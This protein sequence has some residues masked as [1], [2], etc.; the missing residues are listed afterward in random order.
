MTSAGKWLLTFRA[1]LIIFLFYG[2]VFCSILCLTAGVALEFAAGFA[3]GR[4]HWAVAVRRAL[5]THF[6]LLK[7]FARGLC[8]SKTSAARVLLEPEAAPELFVMIETLCARTQ[9]VAP[10]QLWLEMQLNAWVRLGGFLP[11]RGRVVL[12]VGYDLLAG[13]TR[14]EL[15]AVLAHEL[16]HAKVAGHAVR[17]W[18]AR[19]LE[20]AVQISRGLSGRTAPRHRRVQIPFLTRSLVSAANWLAETAAE[21][22]SASSRQ[23]EFEADRGTAE[24]CGGERAR[25]TLVKVESLSRFTARL[26]W[27]ERVAQLQAHAFHPWLVKE[28]AEVKTLDSQEITAEAPSRFSTHPSLRERLNAIPSYA[29]EGVEADTRPAIDLLAQPDAIAEKLMAKIQQTTLEQEERDS[30]ELRAWAQKMRTATEMRPAQVCG[31]GVVI[32]SEIAGAT[33]WIMGTTLDVATIIF[34]VSV[35]GMLMYWL[36]RYREQ[37]ILPTPDF[38]LLKMTWHSER[39]VNDKAIE[40]AQS[41]FRASAA[42]KSKSRTAAMLARKSFE[43]LRE[44]DYARAVVAARLCLAQEPDSVTASM[45]SAISGAWLGQGREATAALSAVQRAAGL[46]GPSICW[47]AAWAYMLRGNWARAEALLQQA[48]AARPADPTLLNLRALCQSRRGKIQSAI[49]SARRACQPRPVNREHAKFLID[50]LLEGGYLRE[51]QQ[52]LAPL[53]G[54]IRHDLELMLTALRLNL[55]L[56]DIETANHWAETLLRDEPPP[57]LLVRVGVVY[58]L[59]RQ[60]ERAARFYR[61][62]LARAYFPDACL[63]LARL[64]AEENNLAAARQ[65]TLDA[66]NLRQTPGRFATPPLELLRPI[67]LQLAALEPPTRFC[68]AWIATL[69]VAGAPGALTGKSFMVYA[70]SQPEA[71]RYLRTV[72]EAMAPQGPRLVPAHL[73]WRQAPPEHQPNGP[74][75]PGVQPLAEDGSSSPFQGFQRRGLW[76]PHFT[77]AAA[78]A[79]ATPPLQKCA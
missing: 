26:P 34:I 65:H 68:R 78:P 15:E 32:V 12:G 2:F 39:S 17:H 27:R 47:G 28:L 37:F 63:G 11:R 6:G 22:I 71:E 66:L 64:A 18:L 38:G 59:A 62:A 4:F 21:S 3:G 44:C 49:I 41:A 69:G 51:A 14:D 16:T 42:G 67:L 79:D 74:A 40:K 23:D 5:R 52:Q 13:L 58:E 24:L 9:V 29:G 20:R 57:Y 45:A 54:H 50:L 75:R 76:Q 36:G 43:A 25:A 10:R 8:R 56:R 35:L 31:A 19:G 30:A 48:L 70:A 7:I 46:R 55:L 60:S 61:E 33:A 77:P 1:A 72:M 73:G 53:D